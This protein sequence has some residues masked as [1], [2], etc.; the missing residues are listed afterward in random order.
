M[1]DYKDI[2]EPV[3]FQSNLQAVI[4]RF[5]DKS[6]SYSMVRDASLKIYSIEGARTLRDQILFRVGGEVSVNPIGLPDLH[7]EFFGAAEYKRA[8]CRVYLIRFKILN[9]MAGIANK[10]I[11]TTGVRHRPLSLHVSENDDALI[12]SLLS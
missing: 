10:L 8:E 12:Q 7:L 4:D 11:E 2:T 1:L 6:R 5:R 9:D 3:L